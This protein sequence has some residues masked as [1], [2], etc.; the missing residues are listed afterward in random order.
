MRRHAA[1]HP[2]GA[3]RADDAASATRCHDAGRVLHAGEHGPRVDRHDAVEVGEVQGAE[4]HG[5][6]GA[7]DAG[8]VEHDVEPAVLRDG[9]VHGRGD[10]LLD[11]DVAVDEM[12]LWAELLGCLYAQ[13]RIDVGDDHGRA[14][15]DELVSRGLSEPTRSSSYECDLPLE[16]AK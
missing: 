6:E 3:G 4:G 11:G 1:E 12:G 16:S 10:A 15:L 14:L 2:R 9:G 5:R 8:V 7:A 13:R